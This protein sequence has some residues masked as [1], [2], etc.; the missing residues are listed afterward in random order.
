MLSTLLI[1]TGI[2]LVLFLSQ[3]AR[4]GIIKPYVEYRKVLA[5][6]SY[7]LIYYANIIVSAPAAVE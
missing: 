4:E 6:I 7:S 1:F 5:E 2:A 3:L